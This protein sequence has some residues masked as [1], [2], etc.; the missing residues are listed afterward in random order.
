MENVS[1]VSPP[2]G[3]RARAVILCLLAGELTA[4]K[5]VLEF[6]SLGMN[7]SPWFFL[8]SSGWESGIGVDCQNWYGVTEQIFFRSKKL[9]QLH[10][11]RYSSSHLSNR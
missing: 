7:D 8:R 10:L 6:S 1:K 4:Y 11:T 5:I 2:V 9:E 3:Q